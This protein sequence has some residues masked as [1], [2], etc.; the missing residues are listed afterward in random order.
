M[1]AICAFTYTA[2][3]ETAALQ[4]NQMVEGRL[5]G[6]ESHEY[7]FTLQAGQYARIVVGQRSIN[8]AVVCNPPGG[9][10][11]PE[12]DI[13]PAGEVE[14]VEFIAEVSGEYRLR[15]HAPSATA[16]PGG[17]DVTLRET[18]AATEMHRHRVAAAGRY[19][20]L[21]K[22]TEHTP[23]VQRQ[24]AS[25]LAEI[26]AHWHAA[27]VTFEE[28]RSLYSIGIVLSGL[29]DHKG[30]LERMNEALA[31]ARAARSARSEAWALFYLG[32]FQEN[33]HD[34]RKAIEFFEQSLP[35]MRLAGDAYG[36][37]NVLNGLGMS[38]S[39]TGEK[40]KA[41]GYFE[42]AVELVRGLQERASVATISSNIGVAYSDLAEYQRAIEYH[43][44][45]LAMHRAIPNRAGEAGTLNNIGTCYSSLGEYQK[46]LDTYNEART[47]NRSLDS[48]WNLAINL[49]NI[50]WI[51]S[52]L[53]EP[54]RALDYYQEA[55]EIL[56]PLKDQFSLGHTLN[57][58]AEAYTTLGDYRK[59]LE[60]HNE[61][62]GYRRAVGDKDGEANSLF[63][64][65]KAFLRVG[66]DEKARDHLERSLAI[67]RGTGERRS[68]ASALTELGSFHRKAGDYAK[69][70]AFL[71]EA[72][73]V[74]REIGD[75]RGE[76][77]ELVALARLERDSGHLLEAHRHA[78]E[79]LAAM[80]SLRLTVASPALRATFFASAREVQE[81]D[82]EVLMRLERE[83]PAAGFAALALEVAERGRARSLLES[84]GESRAEIRRGAD[85]ALLDRERSLERLIASKAG[86]PA[87]RKEAETLTADLEQ[88]RSR[89]RQSSPRYAA[90]TQPSPLTLREIQTRV[91]DADTVLLEYSL[92]PQKS[93]LFAVTRSTFDVFEL[94]ARAEIEPA[95]RR[96]YDLLTARSQAPYFDAAAKISRMILG[97][98]ASRIE[99]K[100][101][102]IVAEG[103]LQYLPFAALPEPAGSTQTPLMVAHEIVSAPSA[104]L[105][106]VMRQ[107][108]AGRQ[109]ASDLLAIVADPVFDPGDPRIAKNLVRRASVPSV[110]ERSA[111]GFERL[112]FSRREADAIAQLAPAGSAFEALDFDASR[113]TVLRPE[114][115]RHRI[116]HFATHSVLDDQ[117]PELS[118]VVLS[119][120]D[121]SGKPRNGFLR[122]Y[123]IYN[124]RLAADLVVLSACQ[125][126]LGDEVRGEGLI[127]LTRGFLYAG[128][129]RVVA[130]LWQID[131]RTTAAVMKKFYEGMLLE[132]QRPAAALRAAQIA[133]WR[134][135]GWEA[136][137]Y[138]A[139]YTLQGEWQ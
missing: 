7:R 83:R 97:P 11:L 16:P 118:G 6:G 91:L 32:Q 108:T 121:A 47:I 17:Y 93:F 76:A 135:R 105:M 26:V 24:R 78:D 45:S 39:R 22:I 53:G 38:Y 31:V 66:E 114:F 73:A 92:G 33:Y 116:L 63:N 77:R 82:I 42:Q 102:L 27:G 20:R 137:Y 49:H 28:A 103:A 75:R 21:A 43:Q 50:A 89:I 2:A 8:L 14:T 110:A 90:L 48:R 69:A 36:Q 72:L 80:E 37:S 51:Y 104:S 62:L 13:Y 3:A 129:P 84:L 113:E 127:G 41:I 131:D 81:L 40:R 101:L 54:R 123:E 136:P 88:V 98:A 85:P 112:R 115:G 18:G 128:A 119:Q 12:T 94:P 68:L 138:W 120:V 99:N 87:A 56:R 139:P 65:G 130:S 95:A 100:R 79:A 5:A 4:P 15:V 35:L 9:Q 71:D 106:A 30:A 57:N 107:E 96:V 59:A 60:Y 134:T 34:K 44:Q 23:E 1:A 46:A 70:R 61:A 29:G 10:P 133:I 111:A 52:T 55:L 25:S 126:A 64:L 58:I 124:L 67:V 132:G 86:K 125:T 122:L 117:R 74:S 109:P 19:L